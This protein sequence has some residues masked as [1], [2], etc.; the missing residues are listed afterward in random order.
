MQYQ[1]TLRRLNTH[2]LYALPPQSLE[3]AMV[4]SD[5]KVSSG[6]FVIEEP[7]VMQKIATLGQWC[8]TSQIR[9][10]GVAETSIYDRPAS[11]SP[12]TCT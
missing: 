12:G 8:T 1:T 6:R 3:V 9:L 4:G 10:L 2:E 7:T 5:D 11:P